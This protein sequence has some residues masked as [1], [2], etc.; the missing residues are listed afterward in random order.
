[1]A[2]ILIVEDEK[3]INDL[4]RNDINGAQIVESMKIS[5]LTGQEIEVEL[6]SDKSEAAASVIAP[7]GTVR[8]N[9]SLY[10]LPD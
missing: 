2:K 9:A 1:M 5:E 4:L 6:H 3:A 10:Q 8:P 7:D